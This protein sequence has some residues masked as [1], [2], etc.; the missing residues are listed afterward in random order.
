MSRIGKSPIT[1]PSGVE[2]KVDGQTITVK[3]SKGELTEVLDSAITVENVDGVLTFNRAS[4]APDHRAKHGLS[5]ALVQNMIV[6][7]S[8]GYKKVLEVIGVGYRATTQG[9][10]LDLS[11]GYS[12]PIIIELPN[13]IKVTADT[14]KGKAPVVTLESHDKQLLGQVAAKIRSFRKPEPYKGKGIRFQGEEVRRKAGKAAG[15]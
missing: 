7:V 5:R 12:H 1:I 10:K 2:V 9:Q 13:E 3:G 4:D 14:Q 8:E 15:K 6:G 11:V